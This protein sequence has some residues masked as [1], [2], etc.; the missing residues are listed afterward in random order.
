M[1]RTMTSL[2]L[3]LFSLAL[4]ACPPSAPPPNQDVAGVDAT[5]EGGAAGS[6]FCAKVRELGC[7][8][9]A[10]CEATLDPVMVG[11]TPAC[12]ALFSAFVSCIDA[13]A[14]SV[15][16]AAIASGPPPACAAQYT[17]VTNCAMA[18]QDGGAPP[19]DAGAPL[20][21][22]SEWRNL[23][24]T[25]S[26]VSYL[27]MGGGLSTPA[28]TNGTITFGEAP[29]GAPANSHMML[30]DW[31]GLLGGDASQCRFGLVYNS[32]AGTYAFSNDRNLN[33]PC[34]VTFSGTTTTTLT[35]TGA[36][37]SLAPAGNLLIDLT[38]TG[39]GSAF[40]GAGSIRVLYPPR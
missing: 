10:M 13:N 34:A 7:P 27:A 31:E 8:S 5:R 18:A 40:M 23:S 33:A 38:V 11:V 9:A 6:A 24:A 2:S 12:S 36:S 35:V 21:T 20:P 17:A 1:N 37:V 16:C 19:A 3:A 15:T 25:G 26:M 39:A 30:M 4:T 14:A 22:P 29:A 32:A 28:T